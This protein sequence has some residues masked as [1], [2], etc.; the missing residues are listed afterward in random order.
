[1]ILLHG[2]GGSHANWLAVGSR[3]TRLGRVLCPDLPGFGRTRLAGRPSSLEA[4]ERLVDRLLDLMGTPPAILVGNSMG[5]TIALRLAA[6]Q[7]LRVAALALMAPWVPLP[8]RAG[9]GLDAVLTSPSAVRSLLRVHGARTPDATLRQIIKIGCS[10][11][12]RIP[13][14][15]L[16]AAL[17]IARERARLSPAEDGFAPAVSSLMEFTRSAE[18]LPASLESIKASTLVMQGTEDRVVPPSVIDR[19]RLKRPDWTYHMLDGVGHVPQF[20]VPTQVADTIID[21]AHNGYTPPLDGHIRP[22]QSH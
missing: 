5:A 13:P 14:E 21:W 16:S 2:L 7:P 4:N 22:V 15:V 3:L 6:A 18:A 9:P 8:R 1:V 11:P 17:K 19:L 12:D 10:R 20:E